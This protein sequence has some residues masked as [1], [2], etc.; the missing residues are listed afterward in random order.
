MRGQ[1]IEVRRVPIHPT[2]CESV[3]KSWQTGV[4]GAA[5]TFY[6]LYGSV[7]GGTRPR[8]WND[9]FIEDIKHA[10]NAAIL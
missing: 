5:I 3:E 1:R 10:P 4:Q 2:V 8:S 6:V 7:G 9:L